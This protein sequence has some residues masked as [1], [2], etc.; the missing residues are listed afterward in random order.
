MFLF[1]GSGDA[2][3]EELM[4]IEPLTSN[5]IMPEIVEFTRPVLVY[6]YRDV[7]HVLPIYGVWRVSSIYIDQM[8]ACKVAGGG[9]GLRV[10]TI[11]AVGVHSILMFL[12]ACLL[13]SII[14]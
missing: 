1:Y 7:N 5:S 11:P 6:T 9:K 3:P 12:V 4:V 2:V 14:F 13:T 10:H 8:G